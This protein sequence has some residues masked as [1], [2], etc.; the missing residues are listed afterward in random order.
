MA[1]SPQGPKHVKRTIVDLDV[2]RRIF[3][4]GKNLVPCSEFLYSC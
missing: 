1:E 3:D 2:L 4:N